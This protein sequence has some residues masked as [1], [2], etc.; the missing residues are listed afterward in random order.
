M[1]EIG[2]AGFDIERRTEAETNFTTIGFEAGA[3]DQNTAS[4]YSFI[5]QQV[6]PGTTYLYRLRQLDT[7]GGLQYSQIVEARI[8]PEW[9]LKLYPNPNEGRFWLELP[10]ELEIEAKIRVFDLMGREIPA[11]PVTHPDGRML[12]DLS[13]QAAG[14]YWV[15][16]QAGSQ[17]WLEKV[18]IH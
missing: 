8:E 11:S 4:N 10:A 6:V 14:T 12:L 16:V 15:K 2:N 3:G 7:D 13:Q 17:L 9:A 1:K 5:D 18:Q